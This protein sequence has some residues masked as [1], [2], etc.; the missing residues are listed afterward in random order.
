MGQLLYTFTIE[1]GTETKKRSRRLETQRKQKKNY[2]KKMNKN[3]I[4]DVCVYE[5]EPG[6][7]PQLIIDASVLGVRYSSSPIRKRMKRNAWR[8]RAPGNGGW[9]VGQHPSEFRKGKGT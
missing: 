2:K 9:G 4:V 8:G 5:P 6:R 7:M 1:I 3:D